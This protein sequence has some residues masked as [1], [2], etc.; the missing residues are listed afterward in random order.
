V[1]GFHAWPAAPEHRAYL[2]PSHRH[3][4]HVEVTT[5]VEHAAR[6]IEFHD[7]MDEARQVFMLPRD[8]T[9][10]C[11]SMAR[12]LAETL[13]ERH[14]GRPFTAS[15]FEDGEAGATARLEGATE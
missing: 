5:P 6:Q 7:L 11:E 12:H 4:F 10:S 2:R 14:E 8:D 9:A 3:L 13:S 15:V 1:P